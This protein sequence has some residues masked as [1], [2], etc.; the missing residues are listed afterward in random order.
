MLNAPLSIPLNLVVHIGSGKTGSSSI[1]SF[2]HQNRARLAELGLL[3]PKSPGQRRHTQLSLFLHPEDVLENVGAWNP[4]RWSSPAQ[5]RRAFRRRLF[6]EVDHSG[7]S[8]VLLSDEGLFGSTYEVRHHLRQ[9]VDGIAGSLRLLAYLRRQDDHLVSRY[10]QVVKFG[11]TR[12]FVDRRSQG[13]LSP[14]GRSWAS[15][16]GA[17]FYNYYDRLRAWQKVLEPEELV[18]RRFERES[19]VEGSLYQDFLDAVGLE[20]RAD[21]MDQVEV[22]NESLDAESVEF[23]RIINILRTSNEAAVALPRR[24]RPLLLR[25]AAAS[26]GPILTMPEALLLVFMRQWEESNRRVAREMLGDES[27]QLFRTPRRTRNTT[28][29]QYLDPERLDHFLELLELPEQTHAP[30]RELVEREAKER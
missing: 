23:L 13:A 8:H 3:S 24:N 18:V 20:A 6:R 27:G 17:Y 5:F 28:S 15:S 9:F 30:L 4:E 2:L 7:L 11:E 19:F 16:Q 21:Q 14:E 29:E 10:Q 22:M 12:P 25:L 1:Q 26:T